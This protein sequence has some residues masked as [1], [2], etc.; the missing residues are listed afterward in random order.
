MIGITFFTLK[1]CDNEISLLSSELSSSKLDHIV[2]NRV[3]PITDCGT[4]NDILQITSLKMIPE[5]P[6]VGELLTFEVTGKLSEDVEEGVVKVN[7]SRDA[8]KLYEGELDLCEEFLDLRCP[9]V[10]G[11]IE[12]KHSIVGQY[13]VNARLFTDDSRP[14]ACFNIETVI[15]EKPRRNSKLFLM[16][17]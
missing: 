16:K 15:R 14:I 2:V 10:K 11:P 6:I 9:L 3:T 12:I 4:P 17:N 8:A 13:S 5:S 1:S 7:V